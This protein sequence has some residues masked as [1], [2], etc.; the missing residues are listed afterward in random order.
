MLMKKQTIWLLTMLSLMAVLS[1]Y[2]LMNPDSS[3]QKSATQL[4]KNTG[5]PVMADANNKIK[6]TIKSGNQL[7]EYK[8]Q[9]ADHQKQLAQSYEK[10]MTAKLSTPKQISA[11]YSKLNSLNA[12]A[13]NEKQLEDV[14]RSKGF[15]DCVVMS[16]NDNVNVYVDA[17]SLTPAQAA[18][19]MKMT[20]D[21]LGDEKLVS[22]NYTASKG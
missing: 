20:H 18:D 6:T 12:L 11:A 13:N 8:V 9:K 7:A 1:V 21:Y 16:Q 17:A 10:V 22:I 3:S 5:Q 19:I 4:T 15:N 14:I 2:Y